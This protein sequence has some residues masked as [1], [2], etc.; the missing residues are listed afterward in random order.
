M[1][2]KKLELWFEVGGRTKFSFAQLMSSFIW[3]DNLVALPAE[4]EGAD[5]D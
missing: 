2:M 4:G 5:L 1:K 3:K